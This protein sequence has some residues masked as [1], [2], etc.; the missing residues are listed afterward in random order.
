MM[1]MKDSG[2]NKNGRN[3]NQSAKRR[4][5]PL[6]CCQFSSW[7]YRLLVIMADASWLKAEMGLGRMISLTSQKGRL[8]L[9]L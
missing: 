6:T 9:A 5:T 2:K 7:L 8:Y 4:G 3:K 1:E